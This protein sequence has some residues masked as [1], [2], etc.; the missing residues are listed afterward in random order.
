L[1]IGG[2]LTGVGVKAETDA[3][4]AVTLPDQRALDDRAHSFQ[5]AGFAI[6]G[7]GG[8]AVVAGSIVFAFAAKHPK[9][10]RR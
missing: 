5:P 7:I 10:A 4:D 3:K 9:E 6:L 1:V 2:G 8:A